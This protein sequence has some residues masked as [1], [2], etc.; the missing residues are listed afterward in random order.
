MELN[1]WRG[2]RGL[3]KLDADQIKQQYFSAIASQGE[4]AGAQ[5]ATPTQI[6]GSSTD[7]Q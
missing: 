7:L 2:T 1:A 4:N 6:Q 5:Q 3:P